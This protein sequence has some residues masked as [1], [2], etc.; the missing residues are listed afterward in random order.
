MLARRSAKPRG[1]R[2]DGYCAV[3]LGDTQYFG[4]VTNAEEDVV[5]D[6]IGNPFVRTPEELWQRQHP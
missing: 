6:L 1:R 2:S 4:V 3:T 5:V